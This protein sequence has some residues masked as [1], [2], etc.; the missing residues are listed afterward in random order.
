MIAAY[1]LVIH[2]TVGQVKKEKTFWIRRLQLTHRGSPERLSMY[3]Y[4]FRDKLANAF[5]YGSLRRSNIYRSTSASSIAFASC[6]HV[7]FASFQLEM[8]SC[9][10]VSL[11]SAFAPVAPSMR[12]SQ[13]RSRFPT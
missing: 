12:K 6:G 8:T 7:F 5:T 1:L 4:Y 13:N 3:P 10:R 11:L 9:R 2:M